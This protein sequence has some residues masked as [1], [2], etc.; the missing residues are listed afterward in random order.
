MKKAKKSLSQNF[1]SDKNICKK[2]VK[3][4]K[5]KNNNILEIGPGYGFL[6][7]FII[8]EKPKNLLLIEKDNEIYKYLN[9]KYKSFKNIKIINDDILNMDLKDYIDLNIIS[10]LPYNI[11]SKVIL[12]L[13][14]NSNNISEIL[15]MLQKEV[16]IKFDYNIE[17]LNKYKFYLKLACEFNRCFNVPSTVFFP[18]P[19]IDSSVVKLKFF[20]NNKKIDWDK[21]DNFVNK[22]FINKRKKISNKINST[23]LPKSLSIKRVDEI[24]IDDLLR[25]YDIF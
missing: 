11:S 17:K 2:I 15:L 8:D 12:F 10:N 13:L 9:N 14:K 5:I 4:V 22:I 25:I 19:K 24:N 18:R 20:K 21:A 3:Q 6:T 1:I 7:D 16:A 23:K